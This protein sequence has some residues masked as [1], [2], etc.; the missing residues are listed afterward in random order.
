MGWSDYRACTFLH[1]C[2]MTQQHLRIEP[3][4]INGNTDR[5]GGECMEVSPGRW[6]WYH[7]GDDRLILGKLEFGDDPQ[8]PVVIACRAQ[9]PG[10]SSLGWRFSGSMEALHLAPA[11]HQAINDIVAWFQRNRPQYRFD[12]M[13]F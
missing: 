13:T 11:D 4:Y 12:L 5:S 8:E 3:L 10:A 2:P 1:A 7:R 9:V 6:L